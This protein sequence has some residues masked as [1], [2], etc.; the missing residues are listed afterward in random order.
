MLKTAEKARRRTWALPE[1]RYGDLESIR[2]VEKL[3]TD[4]AAVDEAIH[5]RA[6]LLPHPL[7]EIQNA[8]ALWDEVKR[9][10]QDGSA[11]IFENRN[12]PNKRTIYHVPNLG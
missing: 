6:K 5:F 9:Q 2:E 1:D 10:V 11:I 8:L 7:S 4:T 12:D 3:R